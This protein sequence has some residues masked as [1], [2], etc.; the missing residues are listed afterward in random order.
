MAGRFPGARDVNELWKNLEAGADTITQFTLDQ[1]D[2]RID[3]SDPA[4]VP[5]RGVIADADM[6]DNGFFGETRGVSE[7]IDPQQRVLLEVAWAAVEDA[8]LVPDR[9]PGTIGVFAGVGNN[10]YYPMNIATRPDVIRSVGEF[11]VMTGNE[12][13]YPATR[14][15]HKMGLTGPALVFRRRARHRS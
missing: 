10:S 13:D 9:F 11:Q 14:I 12:K 4:Y 1:I 3:T 2:P 5:A 7:V 6:F 8:G 15:A